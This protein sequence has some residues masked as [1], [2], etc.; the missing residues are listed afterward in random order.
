MLLPSWPRRAVEAFNRQ[1]IATGRVFPLWEDVA[2]WRMMTNLYT[3]VVL[4]PTL[5]HNDY[6]MYI[7]KGML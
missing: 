4:T 2:L 3:F 7:S 6:S 5:K 1:F